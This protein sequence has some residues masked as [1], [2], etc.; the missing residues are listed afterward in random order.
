M[1]TQATIDSLTAKL[2]NAHKAS[3]RQRYEALIS[4][5]QTDRERSEEVYQSD[6]KKAY[7]DAKIKIRDLPQQLAALGLGGARSPRS[8]R[9]TACK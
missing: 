8:W 7:A 3:L 2:R 5:A 4:R 6:T 9:K 1:A